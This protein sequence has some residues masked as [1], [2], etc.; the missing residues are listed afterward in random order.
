[1]TKSSRREKQSRSQRR[2]GISNETIDNK[3]DFKEM[4]NIRSTLGCGHNDIFCCY[5]RRIQ[6]YKNDEKDYTILGNCVL[7]RICKAK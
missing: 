3:V 1:M 6:V 2:R 7:G 5:L 4:E